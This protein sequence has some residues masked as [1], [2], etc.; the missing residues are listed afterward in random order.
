MKKFLL[1]LGIMATIF[2]AVSLQ[3]CSK[4]DNEPTTVT[5]KAN[6]EISQAVDQL[7]DEEGIT[8]EKKGETVEVTTT[9]ASGKTTTSTYGYTYTVDG[10]TYTTSAALQ[11]ALAGKTGKVTIIVNVTQDGKL[12]GITATSTIDLGDDDY[13]SQIVIPEITIQIV[14]KHSGGGLK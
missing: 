2:G 5:E 11:A 7:N 12:T 4:D 10:Q 8:A 9:D 14:K 13:A 3:S 6:E 1:S